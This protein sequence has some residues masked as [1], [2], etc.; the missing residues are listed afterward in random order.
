MASR[1]NRTPDEM[2]AYMERQELMSSLRGTLRERKTVRELRNVVKIEDAA[3]TA[4]EES[5]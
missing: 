5:A 3:P 1:Y 2:E 4:G